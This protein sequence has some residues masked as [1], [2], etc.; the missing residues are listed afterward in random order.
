MSSTPTNSEP[1]HHVVVAGGCHVY[2]WP[3][4]DPFSF[5]R[6][7][8][9]ATPHATFS[10]V[11]PLNLRNYRVLL[12]HLYEQPADVLILQMGNYETMGSIPNHFR[13]TFSIGRR[14][15]S[16]SS[17]SKST[18]GD[19]QIPLEPDAV[20]LPST[21]WRLRILAKQ[22]YSLA[23]SGLNQPVF[24]AE[25]FR[26][27]C[28]EILTA[29]S[30]SAATRPRHIIFLSPIPCA[31]H[32]IRRHRSH[33]AEIVRE[34]CGEVAPDIRPKLYFLDSREA[35]GISR[36]S[37]QL[38]AAGIFADDTHLNRRGHHLLGS[39]LASLLDEIFEAKNFESAD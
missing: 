7:G 38:F 8:L 5:I 30:E 1:R 12:K 32:L 19:A 9:S 31:D 33:A 15:G 26:L 25:D 28:R 17:N 13:K 22:V 11:A 3:I 14:S 18:S 24:D 2:G 10:T 36:R 23:A 27:R 4:G 16:P 35:L 20:F 29:L 21:T 39:A 6:V 34:V 37:R